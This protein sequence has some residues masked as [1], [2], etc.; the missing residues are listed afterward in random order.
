MSIVHSSFPPHLTTCD[1]CARAIGTDAASPPRCLAVAA[2]CAS[3]RRPRCRMRRAAFTRTNGAKR[4]TRW[5]FPATTTATKTKRACAGA[6]L[7]APPRPGPSPRQRPPG[8]LFFFFFFR[9]CRYYHGSMVCARLMRWHSTSQKQKQR[10]RIKD[11]CDCGG[12]QGGEMARGV[13]TNCCAV[14]LSLEASLDCAPSWARGVAHHPLARF[15]SNASCASSC[16]CLHAS[17]SQLVRSRPWMK[18]CE[19]NKRLLNLPLMPY[20]CFPEPPIERPGRRR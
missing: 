10:P 7:S 18:T 11:C 4:P 14:L 16:C 8:R 6:A 1:A 5:S 2:R 12:G 20:C 9:W 3:G 15:R 13:H 17:A 19:T